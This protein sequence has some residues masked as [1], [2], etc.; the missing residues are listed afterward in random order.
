[1]LGYLYKKNLDITISNNETVKYIFSI[2]LQN[3]IIYVC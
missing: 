2:E 1:M 3:T